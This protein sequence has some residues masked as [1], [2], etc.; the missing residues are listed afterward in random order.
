MILRSIELS[1]YG[2]FREANLDLTSDV[3]CDPPKSV[4]L[5]GGKN[6]AGKTT[7]LEAV[8]LCLYGRRSR[9]VKVRTADYQ[10]FLRARI[11]RAATGEQAVSA[12]VCVEFDHVHAGRRQTY[13]VVRRWS[14][15]GAGVDEKLHVTSLDAQ[16]QIEFDTEHW[17][18]FVQELIPSGVSQLFFFDGE[19]IKA[20]ADE[21]GEDSEL[22]RSI[23]ALL[24]LDLAD[25][26]G[27]DLSTYLRKHAG[28]AEFAGGE[29]LIELASATGRC[30]EDVCRHLQE[31]AHHQSES[32]ALKKK[33][34]EVED[35]VSR[36]G[37][38]FGRHRE[39]LLVERGTVEERMSRASTSVRVLCEGVLPFALIPRSCRGLLETVGA[40][41]STH[42]NQILRQLLE[43]KLGGVAARVA[44]LVTPDRGRPELAAA[45][46][47]E[48]REA[49][50]PS[51]NG[52]EEGRSFPLSAALDH[53]LMTAF[54]GA[55]EDMPSTVRVLEKDLE[56]ATRRL[57]EV[58]AAL[59][60]V[61]E[62]A[63]LR[64]LLAEL[65][66]LHERQSGLVAQLSSADEEIR[67]L[68]RGHARAAKLEEKE[69]DRLASADG[70]GMRIQLVTRAQRAL[71]DFTGALTRE[72][73]TELQGHF[74][75]CFGALARKE[76]MVREVRVSKDD[77][78]VT[79]LDQRGREIPKA[80]LSAGEKQIYA[81]AMLWALALTSRRAL[82]LLIDT[83]L[84]RLD[85]DHRSNL[86]R[87]YFPHASHQALI[88][89]T[90]TE[91][92][93]EY[94]NQLRPHIARAYSLD[95]DSV[96]GCSKVRSGYFWDEEE[97]SEMEPSTA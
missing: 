57:R 64:P 45:V 47:S 69:R 31:R 19:K 12:S 61:P 63:V 24:G 33:I 58:D 55:V 65:A 86:V 5:F 84:G 15:E 37:G 76:D 52:A 72:R 14:A 25:R 29:S 32:N 49:L 77:F 66:V 1:N 46:E 48:L 30:A 7:L 28:D 44:E 87:E 17:E 51:Q 88:F 97:S 34:R 83:P 56:E 21:E 91:I 54:S 42:E 2:L 93:R 35:R 39:L 53:E 75:R 60:Q 22:A 36:E 73:V 16:G 81:I 18:D 43:E 23:K 11:H 70:V 96:D 89:S 27:A 10:A 38:S 26:L 67:E 3:S 74:Q 13:R 68:E 6:G 62:D 4:I 71:A 8:R 92:D 95:F 41:R 94:F 82:P 90:D 78:I 80:E 85:S 20:M 79:F 59:A 9:G 40:H 50:L